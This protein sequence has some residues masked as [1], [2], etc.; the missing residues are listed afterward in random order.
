VQKISFPN[1]IDK[2]RIDVGTGST[3]P[4]TAL[5]LKNNK[6]TG[7]LC[8]EADPRS[9]DILINGGKTNQYPTKLRL[10]KKRFLLLKSKIV[11]KIDSKVVKI[12]NVA[13][14][15][16]KKKKIDFYLTD[17]KNHGTSS[18]LRPIEK[19]LNQ[20]VLKK[21]K[22]PVLKLKYFI[23][24]IDFKKIKYL[25]FLKIDT[26]GNDINVLKGCEEYL[27]KFCFVQTEYWAYEAYQG[28]NNRKKCLYL[29]KKIMKK[30][31]FSLYYFTA[32]DAFFINT[33][34]KADIFSNNV[35]D[36]T[37]D[38]EKGLYRKSFFFNIFPGKLVLLAHLIIF[39]RSF[40]LFNYLFYTVLKMKFKNF[41]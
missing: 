39:L 13:I 14:S 5:W 29:M 37:I 25:E 32:T 10:T 40:K 27:K 15:N 11:K 38:F 2:I 23:K 18:L 19:K 31:N 12:F 26:Q 8:F 28:E 20:R 16:S 24:K 17:K 21:I 35:I 4:N 33:A 7:V 34:L 22:I 6:N 41:I 36:N 1:S 3:A 9:Y 30:N